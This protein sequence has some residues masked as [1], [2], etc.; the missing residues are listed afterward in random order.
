M[1]LNTH[2]IHFEEFRRR[3]L[4]GLGAFFLASLAAYFFSHPILE[5][6]MEPLKQYTVEPL[7]FQKPYDAF[8]IH[9]K[10]SAFAGFLF[11]FPVLL[12]QLWLFVAPALKRKEQRVFLPVLTI[13]IG[14]FLAGVAL[15]FFYVVP[16]GL[17]VLLS[18]QTETLRP[19]LSAGA[20]FSFLTGMLL[21]FGVLFDFPVILVGLVELGILNTAQLTGSRKPIV[22]LIFIAAAILTP[23]PDPVSQLCLAVPLW[24]LFEA[25]LWVARGRE[26]AQKRKTA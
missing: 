26:N 22:V 14:L 25:S 12:T 18:F 23:S 15:A 8:V 6:L 17:R 7:I 10:V 11:S 24:L 19:M 3:A 9:V 16:W 2:L 13:S 21:A 5:F 4:L 1:D 20:Y